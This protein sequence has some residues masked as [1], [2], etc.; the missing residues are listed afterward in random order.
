MDWIEQIYNL[1]LFSMKKK[2]VHS[3]IIENFLEFWANF[4]FHVQKSTNPEVSRI[5]QIIFELANGYIENLILNNENERVDNI[6]L[7]KSNLSYLAE[8]I[9]PKYNFF[10]SFF[11]QTLNIM[12]FKLIEIKKLHVIVYAK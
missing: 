10:Y 9:F 5:K 7:Q 3:I 11:E 6:M 4:H 12:F 2:D 8:I 1:T